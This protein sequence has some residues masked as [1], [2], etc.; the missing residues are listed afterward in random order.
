MGTLLSEIPL[1]LKFSS[2]RLKHES[3]STS[4]LCDSVDASIQLPSLIKL[5]IVSVLQGSSLV[6]RYIY[7]TQGLK[8]DIFSKVKNLSILIV[9]YLLVTYCYICFA[10]ILFGFMDLKAIFMHLRESHFD[11]DR[12]LAPFR[13]W[14]WLYFSRAISQPSV[15]GASA[16]LPSAELSLSAHWAPQETESLRCLADH[17]ARSGNI[18]RQHLALPR[19]TCCI[20]T[21]GSRRRFVLFV[22]TDRRTSVTQVSNNSSAEN[23]P[24]I[25]GCLCVTD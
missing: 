10:I 8:L 24:W 12:F 16:S 22:V 18:W 9:A 11:G 3:L 6:N 4:T 1:D 15:A 5:L 21:P 7:F 14:G 2:T 13:T 23:N 20:N 17:N 19:A 25:H